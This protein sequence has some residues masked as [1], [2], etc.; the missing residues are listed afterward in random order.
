MLIAHV[1]EFSI[2]KG[3]ALL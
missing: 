1:A 2:D 3:T